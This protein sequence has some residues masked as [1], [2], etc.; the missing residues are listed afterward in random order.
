MQ[1]VIDASVK[2][3][4][5]KKFAPDPIAG[6]VISRIVSM[7][8]SAYKRHG[9]ILEASIRYQLAKCPRLVVWDERKFLVSK[10]AVLMAGNAEKDP[11]SIIGNQLNYEPGERKL[12]IDLIA[13]DKDA[14]SLRAYEIKR[15]FG[16]H[17][18]G[19][20]R[21]FLVDTLCTNMLLKSYGTQRGLDVKDAE[22][23]AI[24]YYGTRSLPK[25]FS[26]SGSEMDAHFQWPVYESVEEVNALYRT[27][28]FEILFN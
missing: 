28:V 2:S 21:S 7:M 4:S 23:K 6:G 25:E 16:A 13:Y 27:K 20:K 10:N 12:Q 24:F 22:A 1:P 8:S 9:R 19:K 26:L 14:K 15:A 5:K 17:D 3:L 18:S 11:L